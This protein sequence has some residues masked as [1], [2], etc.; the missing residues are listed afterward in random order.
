MEKQKPYMVAAEVTVADL[1]E[2]LADCPDDY[3]VR[4]HNSDTI[5]AFDEKGRKRTGGAVFLD[6]GILLIERC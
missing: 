4:V 3:V 6:N 5:S 2:I 1:K